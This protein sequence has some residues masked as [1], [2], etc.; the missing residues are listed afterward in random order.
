MVV[1]A[2]DSAG[3]VF[4]AGGVGAAVVRCGTGGGGCVC[5]LAERTDFGA[6]SARRGVCG[7]WVFACGV[8]AGDAVSGVR[9]GGM[10]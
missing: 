6:A 2:V 10:I 4:A 1:C 7:V 8:G 3:S 9:E 5:M